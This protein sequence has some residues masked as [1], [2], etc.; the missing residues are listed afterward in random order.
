MCMHAQSLTLVQLFVT[1]MDCNLPRS[2]VCGLF[3]A[4]ILEWVAFPTSGDLSDPGIE[5]IPP[6]SPALAKQIL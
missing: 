3:L 4:R 6:A 5:P 2:F 1:P